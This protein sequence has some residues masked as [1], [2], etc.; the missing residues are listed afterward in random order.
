MS[1]VLATQWVARI[2]VLKEE[3]PKHLQFQPMLLARQVIATDLG[4]RHQT[5]LKQAKTLV[6]T[7][8]V[9]G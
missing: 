2:H 3:S 5:I 4:A 6:L 8:E 7:K 1:C 9:E